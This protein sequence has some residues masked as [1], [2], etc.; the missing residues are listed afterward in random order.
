MPNKI[1]TAKTCSLEE[2]PISTTLMIEDSQEETERNQIEIIP[3]ITEKSSN[4]IYQI[5]IK[6]NSDLPMH[7]H[8]YGKD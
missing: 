6:N 5:Y 7:F 1:A 3:T 2:V 4:D 8:N